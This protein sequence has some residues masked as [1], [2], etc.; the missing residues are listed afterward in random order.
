MSSIRD[1]NNNNNNEQASLTVS[2]Q[3]FVGETEWSRR[4]NKVLN[5]KKGVWN[6][7]LQA[8]IQEQTKRLDSK[9]EE[10]LGAYSKYFKFKLEPFEE[11]LPYSILEENEVRPFRYCNP[12]YSNYLCYV[13]W[14][15]VPA[16]ASR[17]SCHTC[18]C[19]SHQHCVID[20]APLLLSRAVSTHN[21]IKLQTLPSI[22][23]S[24]SPNKNS[25]QFQKLF[26]NENE[27]DNDE[28][29]CYEINQINEYGDDISPLPSSRKSSTSSPNKSPATTPRLISQTTASV[30]TPT[31]YSNIPSYNPSETWQCPFCI[32]TLQ[33]NNV[34]MVKKYVDSRLKYLQYKYS[35][36]LQSFGRMI[37]KY[38]N[39]K[40]AK[41]G[42]IWLQR[43]TRKK[44]F[45]AKNLREKA[46]VLQPFKIRISDIPI[47]FKI[48]KSEVEE[49]DDD[50]VVP[51]PESRKLGEIVTTMYEQI[52][53]IK[54]NVNLTDSEISLDPETI[55]IFS[56]GYSEVPV[57]QQTYSDGKEVESKS[58]FLTITVES[59][60]DDK[61]CQIYRLD[62]PLSNN[63]KQIEITRKELR[64]MSIVD[65]NDKLF[66]RMQKNYRY[67]YIILILYF[68]A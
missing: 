56:Q 23:N 54:K 5:R 18:P 47:I 46:R 39:F 6:E 50:M 63:G 22:S 48:R 24:N 33:S 32:E 1:Y 62:I 55:K 66:E 35:I 64:L 58:V 68:Y 40:T 44:Q 12:L 27:I 57:Y 30:L 38:K 7:K 19:V 17:I 28:I 65:I 45:W 37:P 3:N 4:Q 59:M 25:S 8:S 14:K 42:F 15:T 43:Y 29:K 41:K 53:C 31:N 11:P 10:L 51:L 60:I 36:V 34:Y 52:F 21:A 2:H 13:C 49:D 26:Y 9:H 16:G 20:L 67:V 61:K